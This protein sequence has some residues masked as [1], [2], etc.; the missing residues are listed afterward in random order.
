MAM[1][2]YSV[3]RVA[4][5]GGARFIP[6]KRVSFH[7]YETGMKRV[8]FHTYETRGRFIPLNNKSLHALSCCF[9]KGFAA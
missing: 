3:V 2:V 8:S 7:W 1:N 4:S 6:M 5:L 9:F